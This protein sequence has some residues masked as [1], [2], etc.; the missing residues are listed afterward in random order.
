MSAPRTESPV[1]TALKAM[2]TGSDRSGTV[3]DPALP[4][5]LNSS[6]RWK[7]EVCRSAHPSWVYWAE[8]VAAIART[9]ADAK[10]EVR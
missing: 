2:A 6:V 8:A 5:R 10:A 9:A 4:L 3:T 1:L 7:S